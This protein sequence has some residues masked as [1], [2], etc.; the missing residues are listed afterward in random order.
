MISHK[1]L[2]RAIAAAATALALLA[3]GAA[4]ATANASDNGGTIASPIGGGV[5]VSSMKVSVDCDDAAK[6]EWT[7][8]I[9]PLG[10][11]SDRIITSDTAAIWLPKY[12]K[13]AQFTV[14]DVAAG[15]SYYAAEASAWLKVEREAGYSTPE[16]AAKAYVAQKQAADRTEYNALNKK[17]MAQ[18][19]SENIVPT[20]PQNITAKVIDAASASKPQNAVIDAN[21]Q[22]FPQRWALKDT[23]NEA[24]EHLD[25][26]TKA[27]VEAVAKETGESASEVVNAS[28]AAN[29]TIQD[30]SILKNDVNYS[31]KGALQPHERAREIRL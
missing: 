20:Y 15:N 13:D 17:V 30:S 3:G 22:G 24:F 8:H 16:A 19:S 31:A 10:F 26:E 23:G 28:G 29:P 11:S 7:V 21:V 12:V 25:S 6:V 1:P 4:A 27:F 2:R 14:T 9:A 18:I 5:D